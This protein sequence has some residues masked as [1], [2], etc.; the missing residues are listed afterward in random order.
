[1]SLGVV[2]N[3]YQFLANV[4]QFTTGFCVARVSSCTIDILAN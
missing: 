4:P 1:M 2:E 3:M